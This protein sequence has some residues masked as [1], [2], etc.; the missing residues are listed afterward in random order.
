[1]PWHM[2]F[3]NSDCVNFGA[4]LRV[5][6][7]TVPEDPAVRFVRLPRQTKADVAQLAE[8][9]PCKQRVA[10]SMPVVSSSF[11]GAVHWRDPLAVTQAP[12]GLCRFNSCSLHQ[13]QVR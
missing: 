13:F 9:L 6:R 11:G 12:I 8:R 4:V 2:L 10:G 3:N 7:A 1:M 5:G